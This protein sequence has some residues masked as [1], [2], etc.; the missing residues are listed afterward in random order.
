M[1][2]VAGTY[3]GDSFDLGDV[4]SF[5]KSGTHLINGKDTQGNLC[6]YGI[7][8]SKFWTP[9]AKQLFKDCVGMVVT[10]CSSDSQCP[11]D[12]SGNLYCSNNGVY[13][14]ITDYSCINPGTV[15]S[16]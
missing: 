9:E 6:F 3:S 2:K 11:A 7:V 16:Y 4:I 14:D 5:A 8:E 1:Q 13:Q 15:Q 10:T 12:T